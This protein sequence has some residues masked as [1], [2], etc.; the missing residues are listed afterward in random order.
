MVSRYHWLDASIDTS[1]PS[2]SIAVIMN[3][4][5]TVPAGGILKKVLFKE[6]LMV[7][8][9]TGTSDTALTPW[10][11]IQ[12]VTI[13]SGPN[14]NRKVMSTTRR[15]P[16]VFSAYLQG[17]ANDWV[18]FHSAGDNELG[19]DQQC[20]F[21]KASD[22]ANWNINVTVKTNTQIPGQSTSITGRVQFW[23]RL[24]YYK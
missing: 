11:V 22:V 19:V 10:G 3:Q 4:T 2:G 5:V 23:C 13:T 14:V 18:A 12:D 8:K 17:F 1:W 15:V 6:C 16:M 9:Q 24:L 7:G 21:G 20:S